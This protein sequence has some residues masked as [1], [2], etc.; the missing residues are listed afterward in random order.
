MKIINLADVIDD[1]EGTDEAIEHERTYRRGYL[2]GYDSAIDDMR[3]FDSK[4]VVGFFNN[5]LMK[6]RYGKKPF[7]LT[8]QL[9]PTIKKSTDYEVSDV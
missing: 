1:V 2:H 6:W 3:A 9:P 8:F 4:R 5:M 7:A